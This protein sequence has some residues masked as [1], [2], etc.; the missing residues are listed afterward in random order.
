MLIEGA[1]KSSMEGMDFKCCQQTSVIS[2]EVLSIHPTLNT[3]AA[4]ERSTEVKFEVTINEMLLC[5]TFP[6]SR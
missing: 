3:V 6:C 4:D 1:K 5:D 2:A